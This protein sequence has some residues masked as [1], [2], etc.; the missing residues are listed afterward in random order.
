[1]FLRSRTLLSIVFILT[2]TCLVSL[3]QAADESEKSTG[4]ENQISYYDQIRPIFQR[5]C[6]GCHQPAKPNGKYV[7]TSFD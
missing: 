6:Q 4:N 5:H 7:M 2:A 1:M 3:T